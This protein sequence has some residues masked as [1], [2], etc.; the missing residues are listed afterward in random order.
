VPLLHFYFDLPKLGN[1]ENK[2]SNGLSSKIL[3]CIPHS[4]IACPPEISISTLSEHQQA[5]AENNVDWYTNHLYNFE[6]FL[7]NS[8]VIFPYSQVYINA[9]RHPDTLDES[10]PLILDGLQVYKTGLE[11]SV[12]Q[13]QLMLKHHLN[14]HHAIAGY[15]KI[16]ILDGHSTVTGHQDAAG[17]E[18]VDDIIIS[19]WQKSKLDPPD[20]IRTAPTG[21]L[22]TYGE[23]LERR[24]SGFNIRITQNTTYSATYGHV[25][26]THGWDGKFENKHRA[27]LLLQ[28]TNE[29][30]YIKNGI[31]DVKAIEEL[32][33]IFSEAIKA[34]LEKME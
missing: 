15:E 1:G 13:R 9:N 26:A 29:A 30:L 21:Y 14:F 33:R 3:V 5:L 6:D 28:E 24:L 25:M 4:G 32:R 11:P 12:E 27:P 18:A 19:D 20:G 10:V 7:G 31:P 16:F 22:E 23:E 2:M 17:I 8:Q 34:M